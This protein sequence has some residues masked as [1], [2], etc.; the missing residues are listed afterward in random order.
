M[1]S[2]LIEVKGSLDRFRDFIYIDDVVSAWYKVVSKTN[3]ANKIY[4]IGTGKKTSIKQL[5]FQ[6]KDLLNKKI[7][8]K[9][10]EGTPGDFNGCYA[11]INNLKKD[12]NFSVKINLKKGLKLFY[13]WSKNF[14]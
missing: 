2:P 6:I 13:N 8:I 12:I 10:L 9:E 5:L 14:N 4:N 7:I 1:K 3:T 11:N